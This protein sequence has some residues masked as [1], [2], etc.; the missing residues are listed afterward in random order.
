VRRTETLK[1]TPG[2]QA[3]EN[4]SRR[5][6]EFRLTH[7]RKVSQKVVLEAFY[8]LSNNATPTTIAAIPHT[9]TAANTRFGPD[10]CKS[11]S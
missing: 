4:F 8:L 1:P 10:R 7:D 11:A 6:V 3:K 9:H 5:R 2:P